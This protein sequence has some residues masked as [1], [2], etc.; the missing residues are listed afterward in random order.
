VLLFQNDLKNYEYL[1]YIGEMEKSKQTEKTY[2]TNLKRLS[3]DV[4]NGKKITRMKLEDVDN[5]KKIFEYIDSLKLK[6]EKKEKA[7]SIMNII[8][9]S[10]VDFVKKF[11]DFDDDVMNRYYEKWKLI[12]KNTREKQIKEMIKPKKKDVD[13]ILSIE[14]IGKIRDKYREKLT[15]EYQPVNDIRYIIL[16]LYSSP[17]L[18]PLRSQDYYN[19]KILQTKDELD[20]E[21][22]VDAYNY[23]LLDEGILIRNSGKTVKHYGK[24]SIPI[25]DDILKDI[26]RFHDKSGSMWLIPNTINKNEH[27]EQSH[28]TKIL[29][30]AISQEYGNGKKISTS[31]VRKI[32]VS[33]E[34]AKILKEYPQFEEVQN[35]LVNL[36]NDMGHSTQIQRLFYSRLRNHVNI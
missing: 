9:A 30:R 19:A 34:Y 13:K 10:I 28:F 4:F 18:P 14:E 23:L 31:M 27:M 25:P 36:A 1:L 8:M 29:Q 22:D 11:E 15:D 6:K 20:N 32:R 35:K 33:T 7:F 3:R 17:N 26:K 16:S 24:R 2:Q 21:K 5:Q 12:Q